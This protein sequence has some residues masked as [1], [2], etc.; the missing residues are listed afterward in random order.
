MTFLWIRSYLAIR[1]S[2]TRF[3]HRCDETIFLEASGAF[4]FYTP[5]NLL[6]DPIEKELNDDFLA[7]S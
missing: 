6:D 2:G 4:L 7:A 1:G 3:A 5:G